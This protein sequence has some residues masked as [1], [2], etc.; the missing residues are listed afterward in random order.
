MRAE[1]DHTGIEVQSSLYDS[2]RHSPEIQAQV[3]RIKN[4]DVEQRGVAFSEL[5]HS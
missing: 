1:G 4:G 2:N 5:R 3:I